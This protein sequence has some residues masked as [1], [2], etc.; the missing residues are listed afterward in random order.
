L[1]TRHFKTKPKTNT[2]HHN[3]DLNVSFFVC[4][5][6]VLLILNVNF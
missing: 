6:V 5:Y 1:P 3:G 4:C 2:D